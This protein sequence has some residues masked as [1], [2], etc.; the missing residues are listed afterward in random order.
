MRTLLS[1]AVALLLVAGLSGTSL[2]QGDGSGQCQCQQCQQ[3]RLAAA[4]AQQQ[5][6]VQQ[7]AWAQPMAAGVQQAGFHY[8]GVA[9]GCYPG[10]PC[11]N[12]AYGHGAYGHHGLHHGGHYGYFGAHG[13][14]GYPHHH[15]RREYVGP[16]GPPTAQVAY[17]YYTIRGPRDFLIDNPP[18]IGR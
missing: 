6:A 1:A 17:P 11:Y 9:A 13:T 5:E 12:G 7:M 10:S 3:A 14:P 8:P 2:G 4:A 16:Q 15:L 18:S